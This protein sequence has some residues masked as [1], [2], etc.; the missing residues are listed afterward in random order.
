MTPG[1]TFG[2]WNFDW[3]ASTFVDSAWA[4][5]HEWASFFSAPVNLPASGAA[6]TTTTIQN[7]KITHLIFR[8]AGKLIIARALL[9]G[10]PGFGH[11]RAAARA[12]CQL[13]RRAGRN[14]SVLRGAASVPADLRT[15]WAAT[16]PDDWPHG[17][18]PA[19]QPDT[20]LK[21]GLKIRKQ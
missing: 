15:G 8:P 7:A 10:F 2:D 6:S 14:S 19:A 3:K 4:G 12:L 21:R 18:W 16:A 9:I 11:L 1:N 13:D 5:S 17:R 20:G